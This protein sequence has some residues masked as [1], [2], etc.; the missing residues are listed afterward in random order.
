MQNPIAYL[1]LEIKQR[2]LD[3]RLLIG[4]HLLN[5]GYTVVVGQQW[6]VFANAEALPPG[7]VLFKTVNHIQALNMQNFRTLGHLVT[8]TDEEALVCAEGECF[9]AAF[10]ETAAESC[11]MFFAQSLAHQSSIQSHHPVLKGKVLATGNSR[12]DFL[13]PLGREPHMPEAERLRETH[14]PF[15]L[16][17]TNAGQVNSIWTST[18]QILQIAAKAKTVDLNDPKSVAKFHAWMDWERAN[19]TELV[20]LITWAVANVRDRK[21][22]IRPHPGELMEFWQSRFGQNEKV[23]IVPRSSPYPWILAADLVAHTT[24]TSG[25]EAVLMGKPTVNLEPVSH[26]TFAYITS[27]IKP[28]FVKWQEAA[29]AIDA[30]LTRGEGPIAEARAGN[31]AELDAHFVEPDE[32]AASQKIAEAMAKMLAQQG[33]AP[34]KGYVPT[35]RGKGFR[36]FPRADVLKDKFTLSADDLKAS[37]EKVGRYFKRP[38]NIS[39]GQLDDS[40]FLLVPK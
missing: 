2:E 40:L 5:A 17:N 23:V 37:L 15:V 13:S 36:P 32:G 29:D 7:I 31:G 33:A 11:H 9:V 24:S 8:A 25:L 28:K 22:I 6:S 1:P 35:F 26:P 39:I 12:I 27:H 34:A 14:G 19:Q 30:F 21:I 20:E 38:Y 18:D 10:S 3:S 4:M 16:F